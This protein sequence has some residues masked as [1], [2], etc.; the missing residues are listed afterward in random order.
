MLRGRRVTLRLICEEDLPLLWRLGNDINAKGSFWPAELYTET[1]LKQKFNEHGLWQDTAGT[2]LIIDAQT[3]RLLGELYYFKGLLYQAGLEVGYRL[4]SPEDRGKG[5]MTEA[6]RLFVAFLFASQPLPRLQLNVL[7]GNQGS[8]IVAE[9]CGFQYEGTLRQAVF[10]M[11]TYL[12]LE[13]FS[14][15]CSEAPSLEA[16]LSEPTT[17]SDK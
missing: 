6:L 2:M 10:H 17:A 9:R 16:L 13:M 14:L 7:K 1:E 8:R 15:L 12:D 11:G 3:D 4:Y 5:Y